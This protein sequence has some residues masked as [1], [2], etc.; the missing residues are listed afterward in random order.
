MGKNHERRRQITHNNYLKRKKH[1]Q[2]KRK[3]YGYSRPCDSRQEY[4]LE[5][6]I[7][8]SK[9]IEEMAKLLGIRLN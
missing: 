6:Q 9:N 2:E 5:Q 7:A 1:K 3:K 4:N 8:Q